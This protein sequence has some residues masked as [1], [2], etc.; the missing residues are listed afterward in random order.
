MDAIA[1]F[2]ADIARDAGSAALTGSRARRVLSQLAPDLQILVQNAAHFAMQHIAGATQDHGE[3][4][5]TDQV[6]ECLAQLD[7]GH[8]GNCNWKPDRG[9]TQESTDSRWLIHRQSKKLPSI[10]YIFGEEA[11]Q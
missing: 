1:E 11:I 6:A 3:R 2:V 9:A 7:A 8:S 4:Q 5:P 10:A